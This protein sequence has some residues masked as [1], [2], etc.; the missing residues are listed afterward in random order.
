MNRTYEETGGQLVLHLSGELD[1]HAARELAR[2]L[3]ERLETSMPRD[4]VL[5]LGE[6]HFMDSSGIAVILRAYK[7]M[8]AL[9]GRFRVENVQEQPMRV[10]DA[11]G[12]ARLLNITSDFQ[13]RK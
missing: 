13:T 9:G 12:I 10:L 7:G 5:D 8:H 3:G 2:E 6:V 1:H 4:C 11:S